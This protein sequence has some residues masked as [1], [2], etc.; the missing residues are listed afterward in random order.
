MDPFGSWRLR[1][2]QLRRLDR[3]TWLSQNFRKHGAKSLVAF[4]NKL[5][6]LGDA[7]QQTVAFAGKGG[8]LAAA[9]RIDRN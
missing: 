3:Q 4:R 9:K 7:F 8:N 5:G 2:P 6:L 1:A